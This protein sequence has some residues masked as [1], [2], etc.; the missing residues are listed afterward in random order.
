[1]ERFVSLGGPGGGPEFGPRPNTVSQG[2]L[3]SA[4]HK[5]DVPSDQKRFKL[6]SVQD[7]KNF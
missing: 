2:T 1:V 4:G 6:A 3:Y 5:V 7:N